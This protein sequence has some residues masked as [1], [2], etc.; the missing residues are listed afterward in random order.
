MTNYQAAKN[1]SY[2]LIVR[3]SKSDERITTLIPTFATGINRLEAIT[4]A[5][6]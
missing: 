2:K 6:G 4:V 1:A 3:E 5:G